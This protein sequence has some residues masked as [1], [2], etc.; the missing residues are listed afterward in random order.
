MQIIFHHSLIK[1]IVLHHLKQLNIPWSSFI[2]NDIFTA[3]PIQHAQD[4]PS[5]SHPSTSIPPSQPTVHASS[6]DQSP[7]S[8]S[9]P[10]SPSHI[11]TGS[12]SRAEINEPKQANVVEIDPL[13][14]TY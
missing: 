11:E 2:A 7:S 8:I 6:S 14:K 10:S 1:I 3:P 12:P 4:V 5:S 13:E 9:P